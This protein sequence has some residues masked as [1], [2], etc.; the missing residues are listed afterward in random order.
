MFGLLALQVFDR[1]GLEAQT[2]EID[3]MIDE[4]ALT[5]IEDR[6]TQTNEWLAKGEYNEGDP[7]HRSAQTQLDR[8]VEYWDEVGA[9]LTEADDTQKMNLS[10]AVEQLENTLSVI[11]K[12]QSALGGLCSRVMGKV[13]NL[14][15]A[16]NQSVRSIQSRYDNWV[17]FIS[18][19]R[20]LLTHN[21]D[22]DGVQ[23][24][25]Y[26]DEDLAISKLAKKET[27]SYVGR[28]KRTWTELANG[29]STHGYLVTA[30]PEN[31]GS[32]ITLTEIDGVM[33]MATTY[34]PAPKKGGSK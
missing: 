17:A 20:Y 19:N 30:D 11:P 21:H 9:D 5:K 13:S 14:P 25:T 28:V 15:S 3:N 31:N 6:I 2:T 32:D 4:N 24:S 16:V 18:E 10:F 34:T 7:Y 27:D 12:T 23:L 33:V 29:K 8:L 1:V 22:K 26:E